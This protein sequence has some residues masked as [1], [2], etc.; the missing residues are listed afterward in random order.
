MHLG[1]VVTGLL[2]VGSLSSCGN[3]GD[4]ERAKEDFHYSYPLQPGG[5]LDFESQ[6]GTVEIAGWDRNTIDVSGTKS[7]PTRD[8]LSQVKIDVQVH[9]NSATIRSQW[10]QSFHGGFGA[11]FL[12][13]VPRQISLGEVHTSNGGISVEDLVGG[14]S[15]KSS[16]GRIYMARDEGKYDARTSN[17]AIEVDEGQGS[18]RLHTSNGAIRGRL[19]EGSVEGE[20][21][22]GAIDLTLMRPADR[23]QVRLSTSNGSV[24]LAVAEM[25]DNPISLETTHGSITLKLPENVNAQVTAD[26]SMATIQSDLAVKAEGESKHHLSGQLGAGGPPISVRTTMGGIHLERY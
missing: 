15:I 6:N 18:L 4:F 26:T 25:H 13:R 24:T 8:E 19:K 2:L 20:S 14:G 23:E 5:S 10:P 9:G 1:S 22:N 12:V 7:A 16:N 3:L 17:G 21:S 11:K